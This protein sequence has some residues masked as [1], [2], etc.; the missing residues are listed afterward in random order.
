MGLA[1]L[2]PGHLNGGAEFQYVT[3]QRKGRRDFRG[4]GAIAE[5]WV[6]GMMGFKDTL[7]FIK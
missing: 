1:L 5:T 6:K 2:G 3:S 4:K 7:D